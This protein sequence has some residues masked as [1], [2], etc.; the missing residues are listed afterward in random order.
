MDDPQLR[1]EFRL[2]EQSDDT[3]FV[4]LSSGA[5]IFASL[6]QAMSSYRFSK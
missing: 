3:E 4:K 1:A 2:L 6:M 5:G